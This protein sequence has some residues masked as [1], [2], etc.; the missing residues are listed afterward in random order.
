MDIRWDSNNNVADEGELNAGVH[1]DNDAD[2]QHGYCRSRRR[3]S[4]EYWGSSLLTPAEI[5][6]QETYYRYAK[7]AVHRVTYILLILLHQVSYLSL[8]VTIGQWS[9][10]ASMASAIASARG[11][12]QKI[13][14]AVNWMFFIARWI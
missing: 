3:T 7:V 2:I 1:E 14:N 9:G 4:Y 8:C 12:M 11:K 10:I 6:E 13:M 5:M